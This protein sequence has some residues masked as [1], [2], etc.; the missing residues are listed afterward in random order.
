MQPLPFRP[1]HSEC[2]E[3]GGVAPPVTLVL[4][5]PCLLHGTP[6][7]LLTASLLLWGHWHPLQNSAPH[8]P[9]LFLNILPP[10]L[11][12]P[13]KILLV[14]PSPKM[15]RHGL[16]QNLSF[17][18]PGF[19][20]HHILWVSQFCF[21]VIP[22]ALALSLFNM[23]SLRNALPSHTT[24]WGKRFC[25][26]WEMGNGSW[27]RRGDLLYGFVAPAFLKP[28]CCPR[29][30]ALLRAL[31]FLAFLAPRPRVMVLL[32][33][34]NVSFVSPFK[35]QDMISHLSL[36]SSWLLLCYCVFSRNDCVWSNVCLYVLLYVYIWM[37]GGWLHGWVLCSVILL[38]Q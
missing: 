21:F 11:L 4:E 29:P 28:V 17:P 31:L 37:D 24:V 12:S 26:T 9:L 32:P 35:Q 13:V 38:L 15:A 34:K 23:C 14:S 22:P 2:C 33:C 27:E 20:M 1:L 10:P 25:F 8:N 19:H 5:M 6:W 30:G 18:S 3:L 7:G 36:C 16:D